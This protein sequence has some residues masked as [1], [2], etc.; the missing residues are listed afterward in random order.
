MRIVERNWVAV[1]SNLAPHCLEAEM[2]TN[3]QTISEAML[4]DVRDTDHTKSYQLYRTKVLATAT[5]R[6]SAAPI[7]PKGVVH[8]SMAS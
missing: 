4:R 6:D 5:D 1:A 7:T 3:R 2:N 8:R